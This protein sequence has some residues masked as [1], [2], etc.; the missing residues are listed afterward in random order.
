MKLK[1]VENDY[2]LLDTE[3]YVTDRNYALG[4][5]G[6]IYKPVTVFFNTISERCDV[7]VASTKSIDNLPLLNIQ[8]INTLIM[9]NHQYTFSD[10]ENIY[11]LGL[12]HENKDL[13]T[14]RVE[15][16]QFVKSIINQGKNIWDVE[17]A[18]K[19]GC[20]K[21]SCTRECGENIECNSVGKIPKLSGLYIKILKIE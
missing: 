13:P 15:F 19:V 16:E 6:R 2:F 18:T 3:H 14:P 9:N 8:E 5:S 4:H 17:I 20:T 11:T 12:K 10:M 7:I 21:V 1:K